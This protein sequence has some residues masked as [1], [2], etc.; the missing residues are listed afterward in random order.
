MSQIFGNGLLTNDALNGAPAPWLAQGIGTA[1]MFPAGS[2]ANARWALASSDGVRPAWYGGAIL[3]AAAASLPG[4][5]FGAYGNAGIEPILGKLATLVQQYIGRLGDALLGTQHT[6][7]PGAGAATFQNVSLAST[8]DPHLSVT[9][10]ARHADGTTVAVDSHFDSMAAHGDLF[11]TRDFGDGFTVSTT[12]TQAAANGV[13]QNASATASMNGGRDTVT[14]NAAG[15]VSVASGGMAIALAPNQSLELAGGATVN[16]A[17]NG[18][19]SISESAFGATLSTT[20]AQNG[21]GGV[22]INATGTN[23]TLAGDLIAGGAKPAAQA[24]ANVR[25]PLAAQR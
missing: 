18:T 6:N 25:R 5:A 1:G 16:E 19:V 14:M 13:T 24:P 22:D 10:S 17:A 7:A 12:V 9:G 4:G 3:K 8:G 23:V 20:F 15:T 11:S 2:P 21:T